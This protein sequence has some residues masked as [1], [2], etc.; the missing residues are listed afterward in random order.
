MEEAEA[1]ERR[2]NERRQDQPRPLGDDKSRVAT[3]KVFNPEYD[4]GAVQPVSCRYGRFSVGEP[5]QR[6]RPAPTAKHHFRYATA[7]GSNKQTNIAPAQ[8]IVNNP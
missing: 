6:F 7:L 8:I 3:C 2:E 5:N 4:L 1:E